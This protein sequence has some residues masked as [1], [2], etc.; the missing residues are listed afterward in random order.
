MLN[1]ASQ[2]DFMRILRSV[3]AFLYK[4]MTWLVFYP[5][6][7]IRTALRPIGMLEYSRAELRK[8]EESRRSSGT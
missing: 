5:R 2:M 4:V 3:E 7:L 8:P 1:K 6:T